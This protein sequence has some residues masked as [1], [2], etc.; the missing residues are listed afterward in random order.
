MGQYNTNKIRV[1]DE[2][3]CVMSTLPRGESDTVDTG[4]AI[5][6]VA[7]AQHELSFYDVVRSFVVGAEELKLSRPPEAELR[8]LCEQVG[9]LS[10]ELFSNEMTVEVRGDPEIP[11]ELHFTFD[12]ATTGSADDIAARSAMWHRKLRQMIG[13]YAELFCLS[14]DVR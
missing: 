8:E 4:H 7:A 12:A 14:F 3:G 13:T 10:A 2:G 1:R 9:A 11:G 5:P 6:V